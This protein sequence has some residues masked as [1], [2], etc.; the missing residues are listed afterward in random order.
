MA[1]QEGLCWINWIN[2]GYRTA[3]KE[4]PTLTL[5]WYALMTL[6]LWY[7]VTF[8]KK[9]NCMSARAVVTTCGKYVVNELDWKPTWNYLLNLLL[10]HPID[11]LT[12]CKPYFLPISS[13]IDKSK[14][15][16]YKNNYIWSSFSGF[17][18]LVVTILEKTISKGN[19]K[20]VVFTN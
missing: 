15:Y 2:L 10:R 1:F 17:R 14:M 7:S 8:E 9:N 16:F 19:V 18:K 6:S 20:K 4:T 13:C 5:I 11:F 3:L 12:C